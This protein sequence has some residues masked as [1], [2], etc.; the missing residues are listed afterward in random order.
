[1]NIVLASTSPYR[2][3]LLNQAGIAVET[4]NPL[5]DESQ[6]KAQIMDPKIL[7]ETLAQLK[8]RSGFQQ[9]NADLVI[10]SDQVACLGDRIFDKPGSPERAV[11]TLQSLQGQ[12]HQL[13]TSVCLTCPNGDFVWSNI[14]SLTM[15]H[16]T[17][18]QIIDYVKTD[19]P[20]DCAGAYKLEKAGIRLFKDIQSTDFTAI[21]GLPMIELCDRLWDLGY[22]WN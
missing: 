3:A 22:S 10:G 15:R 12:T 1:M 16:L 20:I 11:E 5:V 2:K 19:A 13:I 21:Q 18:E 14:T 17:H 9:T 4:C 7:A 8:A 6:A